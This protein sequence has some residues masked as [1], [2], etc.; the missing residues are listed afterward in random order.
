MATYVKGDKVANATSYELYEITDSGESK[1][2]DSMTEINF[3]VSELITDPGD[4]V[5][6]VKALAEGYTPS[7]FSNTVTFTV[8]AGDTGE[9]DDGD[10]VVVPFTVP[11]SELTAESWYMGANDAMW[12][13]Y[14]SST[15]YKCKLYDISAYRGKTI[16]VT[17]NSSYNLRFAMIVDDSK[18]TPATGVTPTLANG[19]TY[20]TDFIRYGT[21]TY[22]MSNDFSYSTTIPD[23][24]TYMVINCHAS[25][26]DFDH[27]V[28]IS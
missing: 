20:E 3:N 21:G 4:H 10:S 16:T 28:V 22:D 27:T 8:A 24:A 13:A 19:G 7:E 18:A 15:P 25:G 6:A 11:L 9:D 5:L 1:V 26:T 14:S 17:R 23:D 12:Y 2:G